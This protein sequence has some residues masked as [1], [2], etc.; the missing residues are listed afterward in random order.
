MNFHAVRRLAGGSIARCLAIGHLMF[1]TFASAAFATEKPIRIVAFGDSLVAGY[2]LDAA[3]AF[4]AQL[5]KALKSK[6]YPIAVI[7]AGVSG[8]TTEAGLARLDW[9]L[10]DGADAVILELGAN[11]ALRGIDPAVTRQN[12]AAIVD[13]LRAKGAKVLLAG[14]K[15]PRN[16]G[17]DYVS[18]FEAIYP[19]LAGKHGLILYPFFL[20]GVV[21][22]QALMLDD[23]LHPNGRGIAKMVE[24][25]LP[26]VEKLI[27]EVKAAEAN[28]K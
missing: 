20:D 3:D 16:W 13:R 23:G 12:L 18:R 25:I 6:G 9:V 7:G 1:A 2:R 17:A 27:A 11:D 22:D 19:D 4:P 8:D 28:A 24:R 10:A 26:S 14:M 15:A 21:L 5:E